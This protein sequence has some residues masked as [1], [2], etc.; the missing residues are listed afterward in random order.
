M[1]EAT[2]N[3]FKAVLEYLKAFEET[4]EKHIEIFV[5]IAEDPFIIDESD[6]LDMLIASV[7]IIYKGAKQI[8]DDFCSINFSYRNLSGQ[9]ATLNRATHL[10]KSNF[11]ANLENKDLFSIYAQLTF[12][13]TILES[14]NEIV[15]L[16]FSN[17][18]ISL[19]FVLNVF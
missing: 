3:S 13:R 6:I 12:I 18:T 5:Q 8:L 17:V 4:E 19:N 16:N 7:P 11:T 10:F 1:D 14:I 2:Q 9:V 15:N